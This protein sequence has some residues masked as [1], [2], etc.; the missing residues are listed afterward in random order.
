MKRE[1]E[2]TQN[3]VQKNKQKRRGEV[4]KTAKKAKQSDGG[5]GQEGKN[6]KKKK[7]KRKKQKNKKR[8]NAKQSD[9]A[10]QPLNQS[11][12]ST[13]TRCV[14]TMLWLYVVM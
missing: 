13:R 14:V 1:K 5:T 8:K 9:E 4:H 6:Q 3:N 7:K 12:S 2:K 10:A 11:E